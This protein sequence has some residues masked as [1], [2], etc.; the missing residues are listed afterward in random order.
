MLGQLELANLLGGNRRSDKDSTDLNI[1]LPSLHARGHSSPN[2][3]D[4]FE[5][6]SNSE[7]LTALTLR[8]SK[9]ILS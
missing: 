1:A 6:D 5:S 8:Y 2:Q 3:N 4:K 9:I 7:D